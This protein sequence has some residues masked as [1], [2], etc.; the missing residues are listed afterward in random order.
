MARIYDAASGSLVA[1]L[2]GHRD[3]VNSV[4]FSPDGK[5]IATASMDNTAKVWDTASWR[6]LATLSAGTWVNEAG[7]S[8]DGRHIVT[9]HQMG[10]VKLWSAASYKEELSLSGSANPKNSIA[11]AGRLL[12]VGGQRNLLQ[13]WNVDQGKLVATFPGALAQQSAF[14]PPPRRGGPHGFGEQGI[15]MKANFLE[16]LRDLIATPPAQGG[17]F[18]ISALAASPDGSTVA[19]GAPP[20]LVKLLEV[21]GGRELRTL[22]GHGAFVGTAAFS[23]DGRILATAGRDRTV[24]IW[25]VASGAQLRVISHHKGEVKAIAFSPDGKRL[26]SGGLDDQAFIVD[27]ASGNI[28]ETLTS[29]DRAKVWSVAWSPDGRLVATGDLENR[30][31]LWDGASGRGLRV[32]QGHA[33]WVTALAFSPD[34]QTLYSG[35]WDGTVREWDTASGST[36]RTLIGHSTL[37]SGLVATKEGRLYSASWDG[38]VRVWD[39]K[40][41]QTQATL[42]SFN[43]GE[44]VSVTPEGFFNSSEN[45]AKWLTVRFGNKAFG[46]DQYHE[47]FFRPDMVTVAL[48]GQAVQPPV[49]VAP[50]PPAPG[51]TAPAPSVPAVAAAPV[52]IPGSQRIEQVKPAPKVDFAERP[53]FITS[54]QYTVKLVVSDAGGGVGDVRLYLN[55]AAV[56]L[57]RTRNLVVAQAG[58]ALSYPIRLVSGRN[59]IRAVAMNADNTMQSVE[60]QH[61][62]EGK[63]T[64]TR[65]PSLHAIVIGVQEFENP[66]LNLR[67]SVAD[68]KLFGDTLKEKSKALFENI[69]VVTLTSKADTT[70][71]K[72]LSTLREMSEKVG[73]EDLFAFFV[74]SHGAVDE[75]DYFLITSNVGSTSTQSLR[76][77]AISQNELKDLLANIPATKKLIVLDTCHAGK[78]GEALQVALLSR[79]MSEETALKILSRAMG[80]TILSA[81]TSLQ[82]AVEGYNDHGLFTYVIAEGLK[83]GADMD[84]DGFVKTTELADYVDNEVPE[85][86]EK[87]FKHKQYPVISPSGQGFPLSRVR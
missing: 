46:L 32:L 57:E 87:I 3:A 70:K 6:E 23:P 67:F 80:T 60:V 68:A 1:E 50:A 44:W 56:R 12:L 9:A 69:N 64:A 10:E 45:G 22:K 74:A 34:S 5:R 52:R 19:V 30:I 58:N 31:T 76:R 49:A 7:F 28:V 38:S 41:G 25:D 2:R 8:H 43:D 16:N 29:S 54:D 14:V 75:G 82:E 42:V 35:S 17:R 21:K 37:V 51:T 39:A 18:M 59:V 81:S 62:F 83:G 77:D 26:V 55:G 86:A 13:A 36:R 33:N 78:L 47:S 85:L 66:R 61:E 65:R 63:F 11:L 27:V 79:G 15:D 71:A 53:D 40:A 4:A 20:S 48:S 84:K 24:R 72:I 73:P